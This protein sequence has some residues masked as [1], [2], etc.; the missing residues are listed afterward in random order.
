MSRI[1]W[2]LLAAALL[3]VPASA[4][5]EERYA[6]VIGANVGWANDKPLRHAESDAEHVRDV[7]VEL[8]GF[9]AD[10]VHLLRD[11]DTTEVRALLRKVSGWLRAGRLPRQA[12]GH[13]VGGV[14]G[15]EAGGGRARGGNRAGLRATAAVLGPAQGPPGG[16]RRPGGVARLAP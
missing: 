3:A 2:A 16:H 11:P 6:V 1:I 10:R 15:G 7:L 13:G 9:S 5:A 4:L 14:G 8:G 12:R